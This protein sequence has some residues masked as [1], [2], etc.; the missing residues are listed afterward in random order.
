MSSKVTM[1]LPAE[2]EL[3]TTMLMVQVLMSGIKRRLPLLYMLIG[4]KGMLLRLW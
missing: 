4:R 3:S 1:L 2:L